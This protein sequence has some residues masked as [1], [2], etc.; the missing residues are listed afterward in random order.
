MARFYLRPRSPFYYIDVFDRSEGK[1]I[2]IATK[3][4]GTAA[5]FNRMGM[6]TPLRGNKEIIA[7]IAKIEAAIT[8]KIIEE[9]LNIRLTPSISL[10]EAYNDYA[11]NHPAIKPATLY[12]YK[13]ALDTFLQVVGDKDIANVNSNDY[14]NYYKH[15]IDNNYSL[16]TQSSYIKRLNVLWNFFIEKKYCKINII[17]KIKDPEGHPEPIPMEDLNTI[18]EYFKVKSIRDHSALQQ[19]NFISIMRYTGLRQSSIIALSW[20]DVDFA[21]NIVWVNNVKG[22]KRYPYPL[23]QKLKLILTEMGTKQGKI[24]NYKGTDSLS[25]WDRDLKNLVTAGKIRKK[26][27]MYQLKDTFASEL[28]NSGVAVGTVQT[29]LN[30][31]NIKTT[32]QHYVSVQN[33]FLLDEVNRV[34]K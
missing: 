17:K 18:F 10:S 29:L 28:V 7:L 6:G 26:Y 8:S 21:N 12:S 5:D 9:S 24:F 13:I 15:L 31:Y 4:K 27:Q 3:I 14:N 32:Q 16:A 25:F 34:F 33:S 22:N 11:F 19:Y 1:R 20:D 23:H 30:H 2:R